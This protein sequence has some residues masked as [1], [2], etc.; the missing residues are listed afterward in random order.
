M[1]DFQMHQDEAVL[2]VT[3]FCGRLNAPKCSE[4]EKKTTVPLEALVQ[5][6]VVVSICSAEA[7]LRHRVPAGSSLHLGL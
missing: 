2:E 6:P 1:H 7:S 3:A 5:A 4:E